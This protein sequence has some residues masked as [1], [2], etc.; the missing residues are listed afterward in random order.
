VR[1]KGL[2]I[3]TTLPQRLFEIRPAVQPLPPVVISTP[4][5]NRSNPA[6]VWPS[7]LGD[8]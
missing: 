8:V 3:D 6:A 2:R 1:F 7:R 5:N 4:R